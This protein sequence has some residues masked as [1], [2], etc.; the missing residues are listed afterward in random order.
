MRLAPAVVVAGVASS[1]LAAFSGLSI[2]DVSTAAS[3]A[4][5]W[6]FSDSSTLVNSFIAPSDT[7]LGFNGAA[8]TVRSS[9]GGSTGGGFAARAFVNGDN[10]DNPDVYSFRFGLD[11]D[12]RRGYS[13]DLQ[14]FAVSG[15]GSSEASLSVEFS[16]TQSVHATWKRFESSEMDFYPNLSSGVL[17]RIDSSLGYDQYL[18]AIDFG[19]GDSAS[20]IDLGPGRYTFSNFSRGLWVADDFGGVDYGTEL[21]L[22]VIPTA[23]T[24][25]VIPGVV[26]LAS[27]RRRNVSAS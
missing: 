11:V 10:F 25:W 1:S 19:L 16:L 8:R 17:Y 15:G 12:G 6:T 23:S 21:S 26:G 9:S 3:G 20:G 7:T 2:Q 24:L 27:R 13:P 5:S 14:Q 22:T 18:V 4:E